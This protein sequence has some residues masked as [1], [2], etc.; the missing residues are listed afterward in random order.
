MEHRT[1][2]RIT[3]CTSCPGKHDTQSRPGYE[4]I[5]RLRRALSDARGT[6]PAEFE[7]T[8]AACLAGCGRSCTVAYQGEGKAS[9]LFGD[10]DPSEDINDLVSFARQYAYLND[11]WC[12]SF[13]RPGKLSTS[14][15]ARMPALSTGV[16]IREA[17]A[18]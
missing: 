4:L 11:G 8:G 2:H 12:T 16:P 3:V 10:M 14:T 13:D 15:L 1:T 9:Y 5:E 17:K 7:V 18:S 6:I